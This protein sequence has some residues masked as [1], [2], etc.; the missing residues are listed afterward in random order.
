MSVRK[1]G[2]RFYEKRNAFAILAFAVGL[3][4][5]QGAG[6]LNRT[7]VIGLG[8]GVSFLSAATIGGIVAGRRKRLLVGRAAAT[9]WITVLG[10]AGLVVLST[11]G[12]AAAQEA[13][14][15]EDRRAA[16]IDDL[17]AAV[18]WDSIEITGGLYTNNGKPLA[19]IPVPAGLSAP[20]DPVSR[21]VEWTETLSG[22]SERTYQLTETFS[23]SLTAEGV[24]CSIAYE[25]E[26]TQTAGGRAFT[27]NAS[28]TLGDY[29]GVGGRRDFGDG[30]SRNDTWAC[31]STRRRCSGPAPVRRSAGAPWPSRCAAATAI[32]TST[33]STARL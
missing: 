21:T 11:L 15:E 32:G 28:G 4:L 17:T 10:V 8:V 5:S 20:P 26:G 19:A 25:G 24:C 14:S 16:I 3:V 13:Q 2:R 29:V 23:F 33:R 12:L 22:G 31:P 7:G 30:A 9:I 27:T 6:L 1:A 18:S